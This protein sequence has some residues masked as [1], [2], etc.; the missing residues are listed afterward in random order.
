MYIGFVLLR[1]PRWAP[2]KCSMQHKFAT[3]TYIKNKSSRFTVCRREYTAA[4]RIIASLIA[5]RWGG[6]LLLF[7]PKVAT[8]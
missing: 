8:I 6:V 5:R 1:A 3:G 4:A 7:Q 2:I